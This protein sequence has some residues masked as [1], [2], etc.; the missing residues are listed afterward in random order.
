[1]NK[2]DLLSVLYLAVANEILQRLIDDGGHLPVIAAIRRI[3]NRLGLAPKI[4]GLSLI[5][6]DFVIN[7]TYDFEQL[8]DGIIKTD[9][10][11]DLAGILSKVIDL[12]AE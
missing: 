8:K 12:D 10:L 6:E 7:R 3:E 2:Q 5:D 9:P 11:S 1:M 4:T